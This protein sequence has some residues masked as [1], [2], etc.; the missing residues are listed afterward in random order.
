MPHSFFG[1]VFPATRKESTRRK[2]LNSLSVSPEELVIP[3]LM[4][5]DGPS[6]PL[7]RPGDRVLRGQPVAQWEE[8]GGAAA[9]SGIS[10]RVTALEDRPHP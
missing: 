2:P 7:V 10:G 8:T 3:L 6:L 4:C 5:A 9:H 1:G